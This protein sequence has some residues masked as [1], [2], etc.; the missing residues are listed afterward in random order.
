MIDPDDL[1][2]FADDVDSEADA[3]E[4]DHTCEAPELLRM[5]SGAVRAHATTS[6]GPAQVASKAYRS[7]WDGI[8]GKN[9]PIGRA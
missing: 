6:R 1:D 5:I 9:Q 8:F 3:H 2:K 4:A 7:G